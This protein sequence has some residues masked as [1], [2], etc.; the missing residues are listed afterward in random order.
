MNKVFVAVSLI[1]VSSVAMASGDGNDE[2]RQANP[3]AT[4]VVVND[5]NHNVNRNNVSAS[6]DQNQNQMQSQTQGITDSGNS[7]ASSQSNSGARSNSSA[8]DNGNGSNNTSVEYRASKIP[9]ATAYAASL[10]SG[11]DTCLGSASGGVSTQILG[12]SAGST[13]VDKNCVLI[14]QVQLLQ[15]LGYVEA[16]CF[17]ARAGEEGKAIDD[18]MNAA[19]VNCKTSP[20]PVVPVTVVP[21]DLVT[22]EELHQ[23]IKAVVKMVVSK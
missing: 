14:K 8:S 12:L 18:A 10:T 13:K 22:H 15:Q 1:L 6:S 5:S 7:S 16:A 23:E 11:I 9:V 4:N 3:T 17:R 19:G 21:H 2:N 20:A